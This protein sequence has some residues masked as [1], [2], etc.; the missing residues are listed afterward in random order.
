VP[1]ERGPWILAEIM[2]LCSR[3]HQFLEVTMHAFAYN[4]YY[5]RFADEQPRAYLEAAPKRVFP[6]RKACREDGKPILLVRHADIFRAMPRAHRQFLDS[7]RVAAP[8]AAVAAITRVAKSRINGSRSYC[9]GDVALHCD[10]SKFSFH[11]L[12]DV[13]GDLVFWP[14]V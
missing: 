4:A 9:S 7:H 3:S 11:R 8:T 10:G 6:V 12:D 13:T 2:I 5:G 1:L 14:A